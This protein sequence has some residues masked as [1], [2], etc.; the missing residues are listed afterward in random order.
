MGN[1]KKVTGLI[2]SLPRKDQNLLAGESYTF[3]YG[4]SAGT[5]VISAADLASQTVANAKANH[6]IKGQTAWVNGEKI[7][8]TF[9]LVENTKEYLKETNATQNQVLSSKILFFCIWS[10][11]VWYNA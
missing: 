11:N 7:T 8:G 9:D 10:S 5:T 3:P 4:L 2:P 1:G 6:I